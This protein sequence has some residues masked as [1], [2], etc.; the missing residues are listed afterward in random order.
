MNSGKAGAP[1]LAVV[2]RAG[3]DFRRRHAH[4]RKQLGDGS[5]SSHLKQGSNKIRSAHTACT[6]RFFGGD[7]AMFDEGTGLQLSHCLA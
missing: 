3:P 4:F 5:S 6:E 1:N 7:L 2:E